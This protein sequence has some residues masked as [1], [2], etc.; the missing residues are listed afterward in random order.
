MDTE[1]WKGVFHP[2]WIIR[3]I[4]SFC[5]TVATVWGIAFKT[6]DYVVAANVSSIGS[7]LAGLQSSLD[8]LN[9]AV[10]D[11]TNAS[12]RLHES[13][14]DLKQ[15]TASQSREIAFLRTDVSRISSAV[16]DAGIQIRIS[17]P[18]GSEKM[19]TYP[20]ELGNIELKFQE[21]IGGY[22]IEP[23][24]GY[25]CVLNEDSKRVCTER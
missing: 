4:L 16:Q 23:F 15:D 24:A 9:E 19:P 3:A 1:F 2:Q 8:R 22:V 21:G 10:R 11:N 5:L 14:T 18:A 6:A 13:I 25:D 12:V 7:T 17:E 20:Q